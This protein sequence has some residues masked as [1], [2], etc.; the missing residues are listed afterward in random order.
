VAFPEWTY[1]RTINWRADGSGWFR[2]TRSGA[3]VV[4]LT[5]DKAGASH[6][7]WKA[8]TRFFPWAT[9]SPD[10]RHL[11]FPAYTSHF[12]AWMMENF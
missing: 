6:V 12:E 3:D 7:L 1:F 2:A 11:A 9:P 8:A 10:G 5:I 4:L